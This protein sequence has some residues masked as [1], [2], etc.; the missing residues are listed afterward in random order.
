MKSSTDFLPALPKSFLL[1]GPPGSGKTTV[2]LQLPK[3]FILDCDDNLNGPIR[4]LRSQDKLKGPW[5]YDT[6]LREM[7]VTSANSPVPRE[8]QWDKAIEQLTEAC[9]SPEVET[10]VISS[11]TAFVELA[12]MQTLKMTNKKLGDYKKTIDPKFEFEQWGAFGSIMR[13]TIFWLKSSGKRLCVEAHMTVDKEELTGVLTN[14]IHVPGSIKHTLSG[15]FEEVWLLDVTT[16]G[17]G[18]TQKTERKI[19]TSPGPRDKNLGLKSAAQLGT[20]F[21]ADRVSELQSIFS[22]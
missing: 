13:Q 20:S 9:A 16:T 11:L 2:S 5:W 14:F 7:T 19:I 10:I 17:V 18:A 15:W 1:I 21:P 22:K 12:F 4:L 8:R 3:P 6:P